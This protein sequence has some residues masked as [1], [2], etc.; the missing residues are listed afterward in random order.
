M[1]I[2]GIIPVKRFER[3][4][5]RLA[6]V[7]PDAE[8]AELARSLFLHVLR[9]ALASDGLDEILVATDGNEVAALA[10]AWGARVLRDPPAERL[11]DVVDAA[12][13][14]VASSADAALVLMGDLPRLEVGDV[15]ATLSLLHEADLVLAPDLRDLGTNA[16][17][18]RTAKLLPTS[19]G[20]ADSFRRHRQASLTKTRVAVHRSLGLGFDVDTDR[21]FRQLTERVDEIVPARLA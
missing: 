11:G 19:F 1:K 5:S 4:K 2:T 7:L 13:R 3:G 18:M 8:R 6:G 20:H 16:L 12:I 15:D 21:D 14:H 9:V 10:E 17:A